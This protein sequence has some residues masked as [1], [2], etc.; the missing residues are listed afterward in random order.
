LATRRAAPETFEAILQGE[1]T[2]ERT[3]T[4]PVEAKLR[5][6]LSDSLMVKVVSGGRRLV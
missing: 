3:S 6:E 2:A 1:K 4:E 5:R